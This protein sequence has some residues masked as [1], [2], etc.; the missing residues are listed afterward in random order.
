MSL[1]D[2]S[3]RD[4]RGATCSSHI[5]DERMVF[6]GR[7]ASTMSLQRER[8]RPTIFASLVSRGDDLSE[9]IVAVALVGNLDCNSR[10]ARDFAGG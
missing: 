8:A 9:K 3:L 2:G 5:D 4:R 10:S 1:F 7:R 6:S